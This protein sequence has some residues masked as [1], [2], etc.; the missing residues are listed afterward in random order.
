ML[1][2]REDEGWVGF[3]FGEK[4]GDKEKRLLKSF[5]DEYF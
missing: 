5:F 3:P 2:V 4:L 1:L